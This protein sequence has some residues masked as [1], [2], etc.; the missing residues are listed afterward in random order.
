MIRDFPRFSGTTSS[1]GFEGE[2]STKTSIK[3]E[4]GIVSP[5]CHAYRCRVGQGPE[6][7]PTR[8]LAAAPAVPATAPGTSTQTPT[9]TALGGGRVCEGRI[10]KTP[11]C[12]EPDAYSGILPI[13]RA[14]QH[15][16]LLQIGFLTEWQLY[17]QAIEGDSWQGGMLDKEKIDKM[18][19][20]SSLLPLTLLFGS[21]DRIS[22]EQINQLYELMQ[23]TKDKDKGGESGHG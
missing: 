9:A 15:L 8:A 20:I 12:G 22:D 7:S 21:A 19:G 11:G 5:F 4:A 2:Y 17:A 1:A 6:A 14:L 23:A 3:H 18:S 13:F 16:T 10:S